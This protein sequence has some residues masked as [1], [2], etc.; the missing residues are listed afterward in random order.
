[1]DSAFEVI[2]FEN[3]DEREPFTEWV[4]SLDTVVRNRIFARIARLQAGN[5]GDCKQI[6][7]GIFELRCFFGSGYRIYFGKDRDH[8][9]IL[10][11]GG[12][13]SSQT[14]DIHKAE[15]YWSKYNEQKNKKS[16]KL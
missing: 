12:D 13:K 14:N 8:L 11:F 15:Q 1:M 4:L 10:L 3:N 5:F 6:G 16:K 2:V 9:I 7:T